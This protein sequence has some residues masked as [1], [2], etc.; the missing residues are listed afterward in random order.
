MVRE[1]EQLR[2]CYVGAHPIQRELTAHAAPGPTE[3]A[4]R[5]ERRL[6]LPVAGG[7]AG[8]VGRALRV[9]GVN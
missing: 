2:V 6:E 7:L 9:R 4:R 5:V 1:R 8:Q 3:T